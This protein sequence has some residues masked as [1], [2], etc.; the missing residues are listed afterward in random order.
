MALAF[1]GQQ[2]LAYV[3]MRLDEKSMIV[4]NVLLQRSK[5]KQ[6]IKH[7][8]LIKVVNLTFNIKSWPRVLKINVIPFFLS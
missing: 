2:I 7:I 5:K 8:W 6:V 3:P 4:L 1:R